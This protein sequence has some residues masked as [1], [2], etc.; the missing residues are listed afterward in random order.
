[1]VNMNGEGLNNI[2]FVASWQTGDVRSAVDLLDT[3]HANE[4]ALLARTMRRLLWPRHL[5]RG[6]GSW[7]R[8]GGKKLELLLATT[9]RGGA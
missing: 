2:T 9:Q 6:A 3:E 5:T 1:M 7:I 4:A 8:K